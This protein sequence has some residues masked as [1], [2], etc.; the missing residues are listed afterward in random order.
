MKSPGEGLPI[1]TVDEEIYRYLPSLVIATVDKLAQ[2]PWHGYAGMLFGRVSSRCPRHGYR[3]DDLD[4]RTGCG[5][6]HTVSRLT[7]LPAVTSQ[8]V[9]RLRPP[10]LIIQDELHLI[11]GPRPP[12]IC[13]AGSTWGS[14][15]P[16]WLTTGRT[17]RPA[18][19]G[20]DTRNEPATGR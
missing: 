20:W 6:R 2:L 12:R 7:G 4:A 15:S 19:P 3:H 8:P 18:S 16:S 17:P 1:L 13:A 11:S 10:D 14:G 9:T 5:Q